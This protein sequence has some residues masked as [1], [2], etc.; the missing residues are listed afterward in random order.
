MRPLGEYDWHDWQRLR[1]LTHWLKTKRYN[2]VR[3]VYVRRPAPACDA[4]LRQRVGG[5]RL[6]V[7]I[8]HNDPDA[9]EMQAEA[10][11]RFVPGPLYVIADNSTDQRAAAEI[12]AI[13]VR[14]AIPYV[15]LPEQPLRDGDRASRAHGLALNWAW[16]NIVRPGEPEA[17]GFLDDDLFPTA[18]DDPFAVL[19]RQPVYGACRIV[20]ERWFLWA[21]FCFFRFDAVRHLPLDFGQAWFVGL[22]T[23]GGNWDVLYR[24]L[25]RN[26]LTFAR[27]RFEP[28]RPGADPVHD[29]I[30][31]CGGVWLH[32][33]GQTRRAGRLQ[34]AD[35]KRRMVKQLLQPTASRTGV[36]A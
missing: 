15:R 25:D 4:A 6:L 12:A 13:A 9:I 23:G 5:R 19:D 27:T 26:T 1:P 16:R 7:T 11:A 31:W 22:D 18:P 35:D 32:E 29:S 33:V 34:Q 30:Q 24:C 14:R 17:F 3:E 28:Y 8:A 2:A 20:G 10:L 36:Q 21:G